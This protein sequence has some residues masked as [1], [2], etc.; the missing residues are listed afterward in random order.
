MTDLKKPVR[1]R[2]IAHCIGGCG[3]TMDI[4]DGPLGPRAKY[5]CTN[6]HEIEVKARVIAE[7]NA[8][9]KGKS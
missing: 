3:R 2:T 1:R 5:Q 6:C 9:R 4:T 8:K 7:R